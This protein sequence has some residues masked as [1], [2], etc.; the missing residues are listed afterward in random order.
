MSF[1]A[2]L[3]KTEN[4]TLKTKRFPAL[5]LKKQQE[6]AILHIQI[7]LDTKFQ[8]KLTTLM[9]WTKFAAKRYFLSKSKKSEQHHWVLQI[10]ISLGI[11][12]QLKLTILISRLNL[13]KKGYFSSKT[14]KAN[15]TTQF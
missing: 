15:I 5:F 11:K 1:N 13:P 8:L 3:Y 9:F 4:F 14:E 2:F 12:F 7:S 6:K 10:P